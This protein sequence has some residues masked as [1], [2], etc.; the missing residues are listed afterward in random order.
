MSSGEENERMRC[1][2]PLGRG[3]SGGGPSVD[4]P[5]LTVGVGRPITVLSDGV[6]MQASSA[7]HPKVLPSD[8][9]EVVGAGIGI[10]VETTHPPETIECLACRNMVRC[11]AKAV[12]CQSG[13]RQV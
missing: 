12:T 13:S 2:W 6:K 5:W 10:C 3:G 9:D 4:L 7:I 1:V 11:C 8:T